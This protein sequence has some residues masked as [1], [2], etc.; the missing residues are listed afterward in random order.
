[1]KRFQ[2]ML[3]AVLAVAFSLLGAP[4]QAATGIDV[5]AVTTA[6]GDA[7]APIA[8]IGAA[9]LLVLVGIKVFKWIRRAM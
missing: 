2:T 9:V 4:A 7:A 6:I 5:T 1:M 8:S 3:F